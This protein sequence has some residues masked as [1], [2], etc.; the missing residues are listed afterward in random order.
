MFLKEMMLQ[1]K[2]AEKTEL[3]KLLFDA[4]KLLIILNLL[5]KSFTC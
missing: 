2:N 4:K 3:L 1:A 5:Q